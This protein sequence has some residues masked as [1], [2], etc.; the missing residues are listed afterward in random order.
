MRFIFGTPH[1]TADA[2]EDERGLPRRKA[3]T[4]IDTAIA[5]EDVKNFHVPK[6]NS[7]RVWPSDLTERPCPLPQLRLNKPRGT[8]YIAF[9]AIISFPSLGDRSEAA[10]FCLEVFLHFFG[11]NFEAGLAVE[12][13]SLCFVSLWLVLQ[14]RLLH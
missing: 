8:Y 12:D 5:E 4:T 7:D 6:E 10:L 3:A 13:A 1:L 14:T 11:F 9:M 2:E